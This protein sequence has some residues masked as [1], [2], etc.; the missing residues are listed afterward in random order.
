MEHMKN[1]ALFLD[2]DGVINVD[3]NYVH[4]IEDFEFTEG[5]FEVLK[6]FQALG[7][8]LIIITNQ[9]G[10]GRGYYTESQFFTLTNWMINEFKKR[11]ITISKVYYSPYHPQFG[12]GIYK[13]D[14]FCRK[15]KP[16]MIL[17]AQKE[18]NIDLSQS[19]LVGDKET[20]IEAGINAGIPVNILVNKQQSL[21]TNA[22]IVISEINDLIKVSVKAP[23]CSGISGRPNRPSKNPL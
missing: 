5:I 16:G 18:F 3:K 22:T 6:H 17:I 2:R 8:L 4:K 10:I 9:A 13:K 7:Y 23:T 15:P 21:E 19:I 20:D 1:K 11:G 14:S 12:I